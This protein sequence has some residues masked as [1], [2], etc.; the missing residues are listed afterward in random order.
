MT[1]L[2]TSLWILFKV[3]LIYS[4]PS[5]TCRTNEH[6]ESQG[7]KLKNSINFYHST[8]FFRYLSPLVSK[9]MCVIYVACSFVCE[10]QLHG[11]FCIR[12]KTTCMWV[13]VRVFSLTCI[14]QQSL[15]PWPGLNIMIE[16]T[17]IARYASQ[18]TGFFI[19]QDLTGC[20]TYIVNTNK[21]SKS[22]MRCK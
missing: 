6:Y 18:Y 16:I 3:N 20:F 21:L 2:T 4:K 22:I 17:R 13:C 7:L 1:C 8:L 9:L 10:T 5:K 12:W 11:F 15:S 14:E 19:C